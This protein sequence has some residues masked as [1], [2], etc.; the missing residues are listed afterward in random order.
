MKML[1]PATEAIGPRSRLK[2]PKPSQKTRWTFSDTDP[3]RTWIT[4]LFRMLNGR[5][6]LK[7]QKRSCVDKE[8]AMITNL[9]NKTVHSCA[10]K[11][12]FMTPK[13]KTFGFAMVNH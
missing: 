6:L 7:K 4:M 1:S 10:I 13:R 2:S 11:V 8:I 12:S 9:N 5:L 3:K